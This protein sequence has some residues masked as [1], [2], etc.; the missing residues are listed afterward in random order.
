MP[1]EDQKQG[2]YRIV[3]WNAKVNRDPDTVMGDLHRLIED[4]DPQ[5]I[6]LQEFYQYV[7][8]AKKRFGKEGSGNW[9]VYAHNDWKQAGNSP[10]MVRSATHDQQ[11]RGQ[12]W[13]TVRYTTKWTGPKGTVFDGRTWTWVKTN[14]AYFMSVHR[15]TGGEGKNKEAFA[16]EYDLLVRWAQTH[17]N[18][19]VVLLG[20]HNCSQADDHK[21]SSKKV[22]AA[23]GG[24]ITGPKSGVDFA[25]R[26]GFT[27]SAKDIPK[28]GS[29]HEGVFILRD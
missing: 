29:D 21:G 22:A 13:D 18:L 6:C 1:T 3:S 8:A 16:D 5:V 27:G 24:G 20:D 14:S 7:G 10:V 12:G 9:W 25:V 4:W 11:K 28:Y 26:R 19:P 17:D 23:I 2:E 15:C